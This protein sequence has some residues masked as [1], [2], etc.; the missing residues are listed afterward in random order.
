MGLDVTSLLQ[1]VSA[2]AVCGIDLEYSQLLS[3]IDSYRLFGSDIPLAADLDWRGVR[4]RSLEALGRSHDL[5]VLAH[6]AAAIVRLE[7]L[8]AFVSVITIADRWLGEHWDEVF[9]RI[10]D[11][12]ILRRNALNSFADRMAIIDA[13]RR[14]T[15]LSNRQMG[16]FSLRDLELATG[17]LTPTD[18]DTS[19]PSMSQIEAIVAATSP[20]ELSQ[21]SGALQAGMGSLRN[22]IA[23]M[24]ARAQ[25]D[26]APDFDGLLRP[27]SRIDKLLKDHI[28]AGAV[29]DGATAAAV[30]AND[31]DPRAAPAMATGS[32]TDIRSSQD[33]IR[34]LDAVAA[35]FRSHEP[36]S[37]VPMFLERAKRL[38]SKSFIEVLAD[39]APDG[40][41]QARLIG[42]IKND[43]GQ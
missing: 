19:A 29:G 33:A 34:A 20:A 16:S 17:Q 6:F 3:A 23:T 22:I 7:G 31:A 30:A 42:G 1:P 9:P 11:D 28:P 18:T 2:D 10:D 32:V 12:A 35:Y 8:N 15:V 5:R 25:T 21:L 14:A 41:N 43:E 39:I 40:L 26:A 38:V 37:P 13:V 36:S 4:D 24:Q 27:L